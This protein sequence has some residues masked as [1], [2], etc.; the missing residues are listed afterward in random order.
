MPN[1]SSNPIFNL[2]NE[3]RAMF[4]ILLP[5]TVCPRILDPFYIV[6]FCMKWVK[7]SLTFSTS[8]LDNIVVGVVIGRILRGD[9]ALGLIR[10]GRPIYSPV[11]SN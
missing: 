11:F 5:C 9:V 10:E 8:R 4:N 1:P 7:T 3:T 2:L 6:I